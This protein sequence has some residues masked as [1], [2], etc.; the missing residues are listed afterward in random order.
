MKLTLDQKM[1]ISVVVILI[2]YFFELRWISKDMDE[3]LKKQ[4]HEK[5][6]H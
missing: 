1:L 5:V 3:T 6:S 2:I 4:H